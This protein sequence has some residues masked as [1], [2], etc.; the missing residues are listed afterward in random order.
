MDAVWP[1]LCRGGAHYGGTGKRATDHCPD[2]VCRP[3]RRRLDAHGV[4][5]TN[6]DGSFAVNTVL[7]NVDATLGIRQRHRLGRH[8]ALDQ[9]ERRHADHEYGNTY[10]GGATIAAAAGRHQR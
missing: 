6:A 9:T 1:T 5:L 8:I 10:T 2:M 3:R 4:N 7:E